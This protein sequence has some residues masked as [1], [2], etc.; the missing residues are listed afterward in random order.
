MPLR[1][2]SAPY[3]LPLRRP[4]VTAAG[5][6]HERRGWLLRLKEEDVCLGLGEV[7]PLPG[8]GT[9]TLPDAAAGIEE[10]SSLGQPIV[11]LGLDPELPITWAEALEARFPRLPSLRMGIETALWDRLARQRGEELEKTLF[12][13]GPLAGPAGSSEDSLLRG[14][15]VGTAASGRRKG[16]PLARVQSGKLVGSVI[17]PRRIEEALTA[18]FQLF[19]LKVGAGCLD[20][21]I[22][23]LD[24]LRNV[25]AGRG[26]V[27][28]DANGA[29]AS[30]GEARRALEQLGLEGVTSL[31]QPCPVGTEGEW[32]ALRDWLSERGCVLAADES[33]LDLEAAE[34]LLQGGLVGALVLKPTRVGGLWRAMQ[35]AAS[36]R[37]RGA[38]VWVTTMLE[39]RIGRVACRA[40]ARA[41]GAEGVRPHGLKTGEL[42]AAD[43]GEP[44]EAGLVASPTVPALHGLGLK[45]V[46]PSLPSP[47]PDWVFDAYGGL[48]AEAR[49]RRAWLSKTSL[50]LLDPRLPANV[51]AARRAQAEER[52]ADIQ[53]SPG[54]RVFTSGT[55]G[56]AR[57]ARLPWSAVEASAR[58]VVQATDLSAGDVWYSPLPPSH[59]GGASVVFRCALAGARAWL[60][61]RF[62]LL[63]L[64]DAIRSGKVTHLSLV[65][66][67]LERLLDEA[68]GDFGRHR[69]RYVMVGG[70]AVARS[71]L[72]RARLVGLPVAPTYGLTEAC[73][74]VS[75]G[76]LEGPPGPPG[77]AG[78]ILPHIEARVVDPHRSVRAGDDALPDG[79][80][81]CLEL[82]G[83][84]IF[85]GYEGG[86]PRR[87]EDWFDTGDWARLDPRWGLVITSRRE[88][89][90]VSGAENVYPVELEVRLRSVP[91]VEEV[92]VV[93][94]PDDTWGQKV[95][96][97][98]RLERMLAEAG[99]ES[100]STWADSVLRPWAEVN[101]PGWERP[102][103]WRLS[104]GPLP[105]TSLGKI[106]RSEL[107][108]RLDTLLQ[109]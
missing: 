17:Q 83:P 19:K 108:R 9:E 32:A 3:A 8:A 75:L 41:L 53:A 85:S 72:E 106:R 52:A 103:E 96:A 89:L 27:R 99:R 59:I 51:W 2:E 10:L 54:L 102:K 13:L 84:S 4:L 100:I 79:Q 18:G 36:A 16:A 98:L 76:S 73:A 14:R 25:L 46:S 86:D 71:L 28:L 64:I 29:W 57:L 20:D 49:L 97:V 77:A 26:S 74:T 43:I 6:V 94:L 33:V 11:D 38:L 65:G 34:R 80:L 39:A 12:D 66:R 101:L 42:L 24:A 109:L 56:E 44:C 35:I 91:G 58:A 7:A 48:S 60:A 87:P 22:E 78:Q 15:S 61:S 90:I 37:K 95:V 30:A 82:R 5:T 104:E 47:L 70:G 31:E 40:V 23:R 81:G 67:M 93:G 55:S 1:F 21:D 62:D 63:E 88:D 92:C 107:R 69:L 105:R 50:V 68:S 45:T